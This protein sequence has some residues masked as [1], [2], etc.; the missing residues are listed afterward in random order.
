MSNISPPFLLCLVGRDGDY[1][2]PSFADPLTFYLAARNGF[3]KHVNPI[4]IY[5]NV[6]VSRPSWQNN[7]AVLFHTVKGNVQ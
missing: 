7:Q 1:H 3:P 2:S 5:R 6:C 4:F